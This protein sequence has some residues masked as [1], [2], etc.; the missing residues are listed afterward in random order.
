MEIP[1]TSDAIPGTLVLR[2]ADG[3]VKSGNSGF[4]K[5]FDGSVSSANRNILVSRRTDAGGLFRITQQDGSGRLNITWNV[6]GNT[7]GFGT[8]SAS[9]S[10]PALRLLIT[11]IGFIFYTAPA[12]TAGNAITWT[13]VFRIDLNGAVGVNTA[14]PNAAAILDVTSTTRGFLPPRMTEAERDAI[15]SPPAGLMLYNSTT[16]KLQVRTDTA[17]VDLH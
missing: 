9:T 2:D 16:N 4:I 7:T 17:W 11:T 8:Y 10:E 13:E 14:T 12:N 6:E 15:T 1:A 5:E 3:I